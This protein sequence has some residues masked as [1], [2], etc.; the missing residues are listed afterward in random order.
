MDGQTGRFGDI[1]PYILHTVHRDEFWTDYG[2]CLFSILFYILHRLFELSIDFT[3]HTNF[4]QH[5]QIYVGN[6]LAKCLP[7]CM[8]S[9]VPNNRLGTN[10]R[11]G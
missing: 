9:Q 3:D 4:F 11:V 5:Q 8:Y 2:L 1:D 6:Q 7:C 10:K